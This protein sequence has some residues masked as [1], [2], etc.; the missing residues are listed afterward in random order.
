MLMMM[1]AD[2]TPNEKC[3]PEEMVACV[4]EDDIAA[5]L[6]ACT[7]NEEEEEPTDPE[8]VKA[9][10]LNVTVKSEEGG[11]IPYG[12]SALPVATYTLK[13]TDE[14][15]NIS[16]LVFSQVGYGS[17]DTIV[18]AALFID[19]QR[20]SKATVNDI[21]LNKDK[22]IN[23]TSAY[24]VKAGKS[25]D[26]QLKVAV[27]NSYAAEQFAIELKNVNSTAEKVKLPSTVKSN[28]F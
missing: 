10:T 5:C 24:T 19:G 3:S 20:V 12:I 4:R 17:D 16:S 14:D 27:R 11:D 8:E 7:G 13:A 26:I 22:T 18:D 28:T 6:A 9:G 15:I 1:R 2:K 21:N 23:L 25:V